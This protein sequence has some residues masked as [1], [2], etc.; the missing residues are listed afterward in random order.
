[1]SP[2][3]DND[4][5]SR[6]GSPDVPLPS[7]LRDDPPEVPG[8][9]DLALTFQSRGP[10][11]R[12]IA[13]TT[14]AGRPAYSASPAAAPPYR[15]SAPAAPAYDPYSVSAA[16][17]PAGLAYD[18]RP[19]A[20]SPAAPAP[21][22]DPRPAP[23]PAAPAAPAPVYDPRP[24]PA[25]P[26]APAPAAPAQAYDS[27]FAPAPAARAAPAYDPYSV[28]AAPAP[29]YDPYPAPAAAA[30]AAAAPAHD[31]HPAP[32]DQASDWDP[33]FDPWPDLDQSVSG[34]PLPAQPGRAE[35]PS[36]HPS[37]PLP[38]PTGFYG[39]DTSFD[40]GVAGTDFDV[41]LPG[42]L[43]YADLG[44]RG[45]HWFSLGGSLPRRISTRDAVRA[46]PELG[47][48]IVQ[49]ACLWMREHPADP[50]ALD[51]ATELALAVG[52]LARESCR[53]VR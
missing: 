8:P 34:Q 53:S 19:A 4:D 29:A 36:E 24:A 33:L 51:V 2:L 28:S 21:A 14:R 6:T 45:G 37:G 23:A 16:P 10:S 27:H 7:F 49:V 44:F 41:T 5:W 39:G 38:R 35:L 31:P 46:Y 20:P 48:A 26:A 12:D 3:F 30:T 32:T 18:P 42:A 25:A 1:M 9:S 47:G 43:G 52:E 40:G 15:A 17:A 22:Y 11:F 50:R 13:P